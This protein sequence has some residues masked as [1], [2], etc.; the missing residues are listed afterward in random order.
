MLTEFAPLIEWAKQNSAPP[1]T[2]HL[3][4]IAVSC[5]DPCAAIRQMVAGYDAATPP[6]Q[7]G[8]EIALRSLWNALTPQETAKDKKTHARRIGGRIAKQVREAR[9]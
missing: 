5:A 7:D 1:V 8:I 3:G 4:R 9:G 6:V 2:Y